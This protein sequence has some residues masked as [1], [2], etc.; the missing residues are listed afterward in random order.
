[1]RGP[2]LAEGQLGTETLENISEEDPKSLA[3]LE[4]S[5]YVYL[6]YHNGR[7]MSKVTD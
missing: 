1:M 2:S 6:F 5:V 3:Y 7:L 4:D